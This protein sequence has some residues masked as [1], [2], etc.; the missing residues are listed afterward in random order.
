M[1]SKAGIGVMVPAITKRKTNSPPRIVVGEPSSHSALAR[2]SAAP[3]SQYD[4]RSPNPRQANP[5]EVSSACDAVGETRS[6]YS[7]SRRSL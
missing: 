4:G 2:L 1:R 3:E 7:I 5:E 6:K